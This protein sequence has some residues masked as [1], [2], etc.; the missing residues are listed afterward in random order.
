MIRWICRLSMAIVIFG[1]QGVWSEVI[2]L[3]DGDRISGSIVKQNDREIVINVGGVEVTIPVSQVAEITGLQPTPTPTPAVSPSL[4]PFFQSTIDFESP[5]DAPSLPLPAVVGDVTSATVEDLP[6]LPVVLPSGKTYQIKGSAVRF[7]DGPGLDYDVVDSLI[8]GTLLTSIETVADWVHA[9]TIDG[10][11]GWLHTDYLEPMANIPVIVRVDRLNLR[12]GPG[13]AY[14]TVQRL[15]QGDILMLLD[16]QGDWWRVQSSNARVGW[17]SKEHLTKVD[18]LETICPPLVEKPAGAVSLSRAALPMGTAQRLTLSTA[19]ERF[20]VRGLTKVIAFH[21]DASTLLNTDLWSGSDLLRMEILPD[22][23]SMARSGFDPAL[24]ARYKG[25]HLF[26]VRGR[27][28]GNTW[29]YSLDG[30]SSETIDY[31]LVIQNGPERGGVVFAT[32]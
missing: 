22:Q 26:L 13:T 18:S 20:V 3:K 23:E 25:A 28:D 29:N 8:R 15:R 31:A 21:R 32:P 12:D 24:V 1:S 30:P 19:D 6:I 5:L 27:K 4:P 9:R 11:E 10:L 16:E 2:H 14:R 7:R 17:C